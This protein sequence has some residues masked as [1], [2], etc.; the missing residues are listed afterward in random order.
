MTD[1]R[2]PLDLAGELTLGVLEGEERVAAL[3]RLA[4]DRGFADEVDRWNAR[5]GPLYAAIAPVEAPSRV[6]AAIVRALPANDGVSP[7]ALRAW[8]GAAVGLGVLAASLAAVLLTRPPST[9]LPDRPPVTIVEAPEPVL[10]AQLAD[11][12]GESLLVA[13]Y[14]ADSGRLRVRTLAIA[15]QGQPELWVIGSD[16][17]PRS[18]GLLPRNAGGDRIVDPALRRL[19]V[20]GATLALSLEPRTGAP[21]DAPSTTPIG[22]AK[23]AML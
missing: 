7:T 12:G 2:T 16:A 8:R 9:P 23:L 19:L 21:H 15:G 22:V 11:K 20:A 3:R 14:D 1:D 10:I 17:T 18:L 4:A 13:S 5:L 6:W